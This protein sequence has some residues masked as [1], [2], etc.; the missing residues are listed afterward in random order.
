MKAKNFTKETIK[1]IGI[2]DKN[3]PEFGI[4]DVVAVS[5]WVKEGKTERL[6]IF[7]GN[8][9]ARKENGASSTFTVRKVGKDGI[10]IERIYPVSSP[11]VDSIK[12]VTKAKVRR[13]KLY[14]L[15][16]RVGK[17]AKVKEKIEKKSKK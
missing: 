16:D 6:Q 11:L 15:R 14:Y 8:I 5:Q 7:E 9:I 10:A 2:S 1:N 13:A 4:G 17:K 3:L 12:V